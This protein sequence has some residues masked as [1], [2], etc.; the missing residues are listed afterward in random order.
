MTKTGRPPE[1]YLVWVDAAGKWHSS[2]AYALTAF[3][4]SEVLAIDGVVEVWQVPVPDG[5]PPTADWFRRQKAI[6]DFRG[7][8]IRVAKVDLKTRR[9]APQLAGR[10][11][12]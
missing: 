8:A 4:A 7:K 11:V 5:L 3:S 12:K 6:R 9:S 10:E 1:G 2:H